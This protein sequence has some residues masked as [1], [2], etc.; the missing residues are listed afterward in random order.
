MNAL[1]SIYGSRM[2]AK[3]IWQHAFRSG[4]GQ[5]AKPAA[6]GPKLGAPAKVAASAADVAPPTPAG[7]PAPT[8]GPKG[9]ES[10]LDRLRGSFGAVRG[11]K[12]YDESLDFDADGE[13]TIGDYAIYSQKMAKPAPPSTDDQLEQLTK[14]FGSSKGEDGY[15][16]NVDF[17][18]DGV[19][20]IGD[21]AI[22]SDR[23]RIA[24]DL[25][26]LRAAYGATKGDDAYRA[27]LDL[28]GDGE[29]SIGDYSMLSSRYV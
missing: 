22:L 1:K 17:N 27:D 16:P 23:R 29:I 20:D 2:A 11:D 19:V 26:A 10:L 21:F 9:G 24:A 25:D 18:E 13:I 7:K 12:A 6:G 28:D 8:S 15:D 5:M 3:S 4:L 14:A